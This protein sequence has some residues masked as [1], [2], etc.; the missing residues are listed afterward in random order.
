MLKDDCQKEKKK[1]NKKQ[2]KT[3]HNSKKKEKKR[4]KRN[5]KDAYLPSGR[6]LLAA[7]LC[8]VHAES[9]GVW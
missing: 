5:K 2:K 3:P 8:P 7:P 4:K 9:Q 1:Q 6:R